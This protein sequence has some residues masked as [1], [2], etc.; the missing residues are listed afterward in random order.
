MA[1]NLILGVDPGLKG[2]LALYSANERVLKWVIDMPLRYNPKSVSRSK[3]EP[4]IEIIREQ[5]TRIKGKVSLAVLEQVHTLPRDGRVSSFT[6]GEN[7]GTLKACLQMLD[8]P[9]MLTPP[10]V[11]KSHYGLGANKRAAVNLARKLFPTH[12]ADFT[13][14]KDGRAEAALIAKFGEGLVLEASKMA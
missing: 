8:L 3:N 7:Y 11:W 2:A 13:L 1:D 4:D 5:I 6:F 12:S 9:L 14:T 10:G